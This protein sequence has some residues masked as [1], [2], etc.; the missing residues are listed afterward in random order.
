MTPKEIVKKLLDKK[1][2]SNNRIDLDAYASG[3]NDMAD[4]LEAEKKELKESIES[5]L[6][7]IDAKLT[8]LDD[9]EIE[10]DKK[11]IWGK[12]IKIAQ[13]LIK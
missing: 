1:A 13:N 3:L 12:V 10:N 9:H 2:E 5:L 7:L 4:Q 8:P 11:H 6:V